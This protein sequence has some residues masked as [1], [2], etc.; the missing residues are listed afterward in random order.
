MYLL[1]LVSFFSFLNASE[2]DFLDI[3]CSDRLVKI[4]EKHISYEFLILLE[5]AAR[6]NN[7][8]E[9]VQYSFLG[10]QEELE[11]LI[12]SYKN[13]EEAQSHITII[14]YLCVLELQLEKFEFY[15]KTHA[16][17]LIDIIKK[18][19][20]DV[21]ILENVANE[22]IR[23]KIK[24]SFVEIRQLARALEENI[25]K[26]EF[27]N[28]LIK[29]SRIE[30]VLHHDN[31]LIITAI[32]EDTSVAHRKTVVYNNIDNKNINF[33]HTRPLYFSIDKKYLI[34][35]K[36]NNHDTKYLIINLSTLDTRV[37]E[38]NEVTIVDTDDEND[39]FRNREKIIIRNKK[40]NDEIAFPSSVYA[41]QDRQCFFNWFT[42]YNNFIFKKDNILHVIQGL[43]NF[44]K[45][46]K[47]NVDDEHSLLSF[48]GMKKKSKKC[49]FY[50]CSFV[51]DIQL[52]NEIEIKKYT[53]HDIKELKKW[54]DHTLRPP[55]NLPLSYGM[56]LVAGTSGF[57]LKYRAN[58]NLY[59]VLKNYKIESMHAFKDNIIFHEKLDKGFY[60]PSE[61]N[62]YHINREKFL[63]DILEN[64]TQFVPRTILLLFAFAIF[65][66][67]FFNRT[68]LISLILVGMF[69]H[70]GMVQKIKSY[71]YCDATRI[72]DMLLNANNSFEYQVFNF[73]G[74][75]F[76]C[77]KKDF[78]KTFSRFNRYFSHAIQDGRNHNIAY[79]HHC[80]ECAVPLFFVPAIFAVHAVKSGNIIKSDSRERFKKI[81]YF[82]MKIVCPEYDVK[83]ENYYGHK[84]AEHIRVDGEC[85]LGH[86]DC[87]TMQPPTYYKKF[88]PYVKKLFDT[89]E[90]YK[91]FKNNI[92]S[93]SNH[94]K[95]KS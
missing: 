55:I 53:L 54:K 63:S 36:S 81:S 42:S 45:I 88:F 72:K 87:F 20:I 77:Q 71:T 47:I 49:R 69:L 28:N 61:H 41:C 58:E 21:E 67:C 79:Y 73:I 85:F 27:K 24:L 64:K 91:E 26:L 1:L 52:W 8:D 44:D 75:C 59:P 4:H 51:N 60:M 86:L 12:L 23:N 65:D 31:F 15:I 22:K 74:N 30:K 25:K 32:N 80:H 3:K 76:L 5:V 84:T 10:S 92:I 37:I 46:S 2:K 18:Q 16:A 70:S 35:E 57:C 62:I 82:L 34:E 83:F 17:A 48:F 14:N 89:K 11:T 39:I 43:E 56:H 40:N 66:E 19:N 95:I 90:D 13:L 93:K 7:F 50:E 6:I 33:L 9:S 94:I 29:E 78:K 68:I 38:N